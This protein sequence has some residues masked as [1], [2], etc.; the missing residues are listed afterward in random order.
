MEIDRKDIERRER[1]YKA[2]QNKKHK[3]IETV[4][5]EAELQKA[6]SLYKKNP[7]IFLALREFRK[8]NYKDTGVATKN[9]LEIK[10]KAKLSR[11][12]MNIWRKEFPLLIK[13]NNLFRDF[14]IG[15]W[16]DPEKV[17]ADNQKNMVSS[18]GKKTRKTQQEKNDKLKEEMNKA[19][20]IL[21]QMANP[22]L[23]ETEKWKISNN[24]RRQVDIINN[25]V[26]EWWLVKVDWIT[27]LYNINWK[28]LSRGKEII[29]QNINKINVKHFGDLKALSDIL[30]TAFKQNRLID[31][32]STDNIAVGVHDIYDKIVENANNQRINV[33]PDLEPQ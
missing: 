2:E 5:K 20:I 27:E 14:M 11:T 4:K 31:G 7:L 23:T 8:R 12:N 26:A 16:I 18:Y 25:T 33:N 22:N 9:I 21:K 17:K 3:L 19:T 1:E 6:I 29:F 10:P 15:V 24:W 28:L 32:K 13:N 30:D